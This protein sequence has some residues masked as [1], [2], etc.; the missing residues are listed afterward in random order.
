M[1]LIDQHAAHERVLFEEFYHRFQAGQVVSQRL[2]QPVALTLTEQETQLFLENEALFRRFGFGLS[3]LGPNT[4]ALEEVPYLFEHPAQF[5][6]FTELLDALSLGGS[7]TPYESR[8]LTIATMA[9]KA[10]VKAN[11]RLSVQEG[12]ALIRQ[13]MELENPFHCPHG[14]PTIIELTKYE[15]EKKFKR[16]V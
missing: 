15:L 9:C 12:Y 11:D 2:L 13:L 5:G 7:T 3:Q 14:R 4:F 1:F 6:F 16:I 10:A 8:L